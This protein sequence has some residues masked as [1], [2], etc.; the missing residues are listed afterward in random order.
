[1]SKFAAIS[2]T[3]LKEQ[4]EWLDQKAEE[5]ALSKSVLVRAAIQ[6]LKEAWQKKITD[7]RENQRLNNAVKTALKRKEDKKH[8]KGRGTT[9]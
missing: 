6:L 4:Y 7:Y 9:K 8:D 2:A 3:V 1:M 5:T